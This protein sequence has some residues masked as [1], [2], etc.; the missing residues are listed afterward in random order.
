MS[1]NVSGTYTLPVGNPVSP[2]TTITSSW[3][4][5][6]LQDIANALTDSLSRSGNGNMSVPLL[7][8][9]GSAAAPIFSFV[10]DPNT[11]IYRSG[12]DT[13][14]FA[15][16]STER[17]LIG[18]TG[19][20]NIGGSGSSAISLLAGKNVTGGTAASG[21]RSDGQIQSDVTSSA[22][23]FASAPSTA[24]AAFTLASLVHYSAVQGTLGAGSAVT[25]QTGYLADSTLTGA[26][27]NYGFRGSIASGANRWNL[28]MDGT[29]ANYLA[30]NVQFGTT[31]TPSSSQP[32]ALVQA[33]GAMLG[34]VDTNGININ[35]YK[36]STPTQTAFMAFI[37]NGS[38][39]GSITRASAATVAYNTSSD[40]RLKTAIE[41]APAA[42]PLLDAI[43]VVSFDWKV[44]GSH[45]PFGVIAQDLV[46]VAPNAVSP[47]EGEIPWGV[48]YS[49]L[50]PMLIKEIQD[51]RKRVAQLE[52]AGN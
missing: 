8:P 38:V 51:L 46:K 32:G 22:A 16:G 5:T 15:T 25:V 13:L 27:T 10:A 2:A 6:T 34:A 36:P 49:K 26:T 19:N 30:G 17:M 43:E 21:V 31:A 45:E 37:E 41:E 12:A 7:M 39:I 18:A 24:T 35:L 4:N 44:D 20:V 28:Y 48:D 11:G 14:G 40:R 29:A 47:G 3:A 42:G 33:N 23:M 1:R 9:F 52:A 50:V